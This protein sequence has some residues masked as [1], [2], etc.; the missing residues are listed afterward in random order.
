MSDEDL[1]SLAVKIAM[2]D[3][4]FQQGMQS[5]KTSMSVIDSNFKE[6]IAGIKDWGT[7]LDGLK[8]NAQA[9]GDKIGIQKQVLQTYQEQLDK[10]KISLEN[11]S[12]AMMDLK[13]K[14]DTAKTSWEQSKT[15]LGANDE[16]TL[17][18]KK[19]FEDLNKQYTDS[20]S[21]V[22]SNAKSVEG[23]TIQTNNASGKLKIM[24]SN[25]SGVSKQLDE[26]S[27]KQS[28][29]GQA[30]DKLGINMETLK[31]SFGAIG[32]AAGGFLKSA[33]DSAGELQDSQANLEQTIKSTGDASGLSAKQMEDLAEKEQGVSTFSKDTVEAGEAMLGTFTN[34]GKNVFPMATQA[35]LDM[36]Q[37]MGT[38]PKDAAI[39]LGKALNDPVKGITALT[40]VGVTFSASQKNAIAAMVKT[41]DTAGA[42]KLIIAELN[43]EFG[44]QA[45]AAASTFTGSQKQMQN[46]L[47]ST[48]ETIGAA[49]IPVITQLAKVLATIITPIADFIAKNP[50]FT[51]AVLAIVA[52]LGTLVGGLTV[53]N[54]VTQAFGLTLDTEVLPTIGLAILAVAAFA[55]IAFVVVKN[56]GTI[57]SFFNKLWT[58]IKTDTETTWNGIGTFF[59]TLWTSITTTVTTIWNSIG[60]FFINLWVGITNT[61]QSAWNGIKTFFTTVWN[62]IVTG[63][64]AIV[65]PFILGIT[66]IFNSMRDGLTTILN[67]LKDY[68][69][70][71]WNLIKTIFLGTILLILDLVTGNF[72]KL[73]TDTQSIFSK[74]KEAFTEIWD[75]IK[76]IFTGVVTAIS[77]FLKTEWN[78]IVTI[79]KTIWDGLKTFMSTLWEG[80]KTDAS[81]A[82]NSLKSSVTSICA[83]IVSG[84]K[85]LWN[86]LLSWFNELPGKLKTT[87]SNMFTSMKSGVTST[88]SNV[89]S[90]IV[91]GITSAIDWL[92]AL[93]S[94]AFTWGKD[95]IDGIVSGI[96]SAAGAVSTSIKG[97]AQDIRSFLHFSVP[98]QGPLVDYESW[99]PDFMGGLAK[100]IENSK[101]LVT[102]AINSLVTDVNVGM[103]LD[104]AAAVSGSVGNV[105]SAANQSSSK[106][107]DSIINFNGSYTFSNQKDINYFMNQAALIVQRKK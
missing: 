98:D 48:K 4:S 105:G 63:V 77:G 38:A 95:M 14:V 59:T 82:W 18:L 31:L 36:S 102:N 9:L 75:G 53:L 7:S 104:P 80:I 34:I 21:K 43:K 15:T 42:Q 25:L 39:Q 83:S 92:K 107:G 72:T 60:T 86:G 55:A 12:K 27:K 89:K 84:A 61:T 40:R 87:G 93:P 20:E 73:S 88:I 5:L 44:G 62:D 78:G 58:D 16:A 100:G 32:L 49:L 28:M 52:V 76:L 37:K 96:K 24:E 85:D 67:G 22:R 17:K 65:N 35:L 68:F 69:T 97:V 30:S 33:I 57:S 47:T 91:S 74:L 50:Q 99:M 13:G 46:E 2:N 23:Y 101:S 26:A 1:G 64:M 56:W 94:E 45:A 71:V 66:N 79:A 106:Q 41:G 70:G 90:A 81:T 54:T 3:S 8:A 11:N 29:F 10:S 19:D 103:K 51:A 6:S